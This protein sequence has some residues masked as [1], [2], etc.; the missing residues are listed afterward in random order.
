[1]T[2]MIVGALRQRRAEYEEA[3]RLSEGSES[4]WSDPGSDSG[5]EVVLEAVIGPL[6]ILI[7]GDVVATLG[8][9]QAGL[10]P[11]PVVH[12]MWE[13]QLVRAYNEVLV[14]CSQRW[15][16]CRVERRSVQKSL[17]VR[18]RWPWSWWR[19]MGRTHCS[20]VVEQQYR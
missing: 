3:R 13:A 16:C 20:L 12:Q 19:G 11:A 14:S 10:T 18:G 9:T 2:M 8:D 17:A 7:E 6:A 5:S 15:S 1:M 4:C